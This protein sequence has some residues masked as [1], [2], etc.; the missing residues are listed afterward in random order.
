MRV[1]F[2]TQNND[3]GFPH[4]F[5]KAYD[6]QTLI[7]DSIEVNLFNMLEL[8]PV[9]VLVEYRDLLKDKVL[10]SVSENYVVTIN[11]YLHYLS[12][13]NNYLEKNAQNG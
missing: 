9:P 5:M 11:M 3:Q 8:V 7:K 4:I 13:V 10:N 1:E 2:Y 6:D 12:I